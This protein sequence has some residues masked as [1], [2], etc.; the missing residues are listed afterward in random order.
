MYALVNTMDRVSPYLGTVISLHRTVAA[1][2]RADAV[3]QRRTRRRNGQH[4]YIPTTIV[5]LVTPL[6]RQ[7][8]ASRRW[9]LERDCRHVA[10]EEHDYVY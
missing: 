9:V 10:P 6:R 2:D 7:P 4:S 1:A 5:E 3:L 8:G